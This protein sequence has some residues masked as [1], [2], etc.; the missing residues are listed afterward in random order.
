MIPI[1]LSIPENSP[2]TKIAVSPGRLTRCPDMR[3]C[4]FFL[5]VLASACTTAKADL[6]LISPLG[7]VSFKDVPIPDPAQFRY[8]STKPNVFGEPGSIYIRYLVRNTEF[9][10]SE[11]GAKFLQDFA[12]QLSAQAWSQIQHMEHSPDL[13]TSSHVLIGF[14]ENVQLIVEFDRSTGQLL[15][16]RNILNQE[17]FQFQREQFRIPPM[18]IADTWEIG[19]VPLPLGFERE[20]FENPMHA[21]FVVAPKV[22]LHGSKFLRLFRSS[23][24]EEL[25]RLVADMRTKLRLKNWT[26]VSLKTSTDRYRFL[27]ID[28][29]SDEAVKSYPAAS[30]KRWEINAKRAGYTASVKILSPGATGTIVEVSRRFET[31]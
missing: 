24:R 21:R 16:A 28:S 15:I 17:D 26:R 25:D 29:T 11:S 13:K 1:R 18:R 2:G 19:G 22:L 7:V 27:Q 10:N 23:W 14:K 6:R 20:G 12:K 31:S 3:L 4:V 8:E 9:R 5:C 30:R